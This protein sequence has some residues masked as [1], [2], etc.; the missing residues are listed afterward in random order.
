MTIKFKTDFYRTEGGR[1]FYLDPE[2]GVYTF[3]DGVALPEGWADGLKLEPIGTIT[4][5]ESGG[6][7][8][9]FFEGQGICPYCRKYV[10]NC[11]CSDADV[12]PDMGARG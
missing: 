12:Y 10:E 8:L 5:F 1:Y 2:T 9:N 3:D 6:K 4:F 7:C 11:E